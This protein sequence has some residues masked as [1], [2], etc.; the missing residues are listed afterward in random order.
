[1]KEKF[2]ISLFWFSFACMLGAIGSIELNK[3]SI[4]EGFALAIFWLIVF[5]FSLYKTDN[6]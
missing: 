4:G 5:T 2:Y 3:I 6:K 1:M